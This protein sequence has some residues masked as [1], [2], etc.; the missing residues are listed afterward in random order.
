MVPGGNTSPDATV[1]YPA[2]TPPIPPPRIRANLDPGPLRAAP[3]A[4][5]SAPQI[6]IPWSPLAAAKERT[7]ITTYAASL[8]AVAIIVPSALRATHPGADGILGGWDLSPVD[9]FMGMTSSVGDYPAMRTRRS[10]VPFEDGQPPPEGRE[11]PRVLGLLTK[12]VVF[13]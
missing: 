11:N 1:K 9:S 6:P 8:S 13:F 3:A 4:A 5:P 7:P 12:F 2:T 10:I